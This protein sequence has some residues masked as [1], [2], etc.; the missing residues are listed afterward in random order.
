VLSALKKKKKTKPTPKAKAAT[1]TVP[2]SEAS[3]SFADLGKP[4]SLTL[5][6]L[7]R[8]K[9][10]K[11]RA[12]QQDE[13]ISLGGLLDNKDS[14]RQNHSSFLSIVD[15]D[16]IGEGLEV[17]MSM[18]LGESSTKLARGSVAT[19]EKQNEGDLETGNMNDQRILVDTPNKTLLSRFE[20][21]VK[22]LEL[23]WVRRA[24]YI[25]FLVFLICDIILVIVLLLR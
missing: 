5:Q 8:S 19:I 25:G 2:N 12:K 17:M 16:A 4:E 20:D 24:V 14:T 1:H 21:L 18:E 3:M 22:L 9:P 11:E 15:E 6:E 13:S 23:P 7:E 10:G